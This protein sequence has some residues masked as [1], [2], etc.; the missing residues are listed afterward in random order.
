MQTSPMGMI[1]TQFIRQLSLYDKFRIVDA[2]A[3]NGCP[4]IVSG[5]IDFAGGAVIVCQTI[6][7]AVH[8]INRNNYRTSFHKTSG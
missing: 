5:E 3:A 8:A 7:H 4:S 1:F 6:L 2:I